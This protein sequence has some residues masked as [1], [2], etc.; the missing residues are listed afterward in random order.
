MIQKLSVGMKDLKKQLGLIDAR[1]AK[2]S[3]RRGFEDKEETD[4][5]DGLANFLSCLNESLEAVEPGCAVKVFR[6]KR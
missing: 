3:G 2:L 6:G 4:L 5:L 1:V